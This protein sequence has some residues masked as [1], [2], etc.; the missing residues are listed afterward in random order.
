MTPQ[1]SAAVN[2]LIES[3]VTAED[4]DVFG[5]SG[6]GAVDLDSQSLTIPGNIQRD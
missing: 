1:S 5:D 6:T 4:L 3:K 2:D